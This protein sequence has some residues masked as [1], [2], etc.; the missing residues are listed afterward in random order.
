MVPLTVRTFNIS[1]RYI[2]CVLPTAYKTTVEMYTFFY[3]Q[4]TLMSNLFNGVYIPIVI[5]RLN[6]FLKPC[7]RYAVDTSVDIGCGI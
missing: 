2:K 7:K 3:A 6:I 5:Y 4:L 1:L